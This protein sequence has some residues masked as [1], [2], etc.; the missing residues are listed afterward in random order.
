MAFADYRRDLLAAEFDASRMLDRY[1]HSGQS[2]A[3]FGAPP[4]EEPEFKRDLALRLHEA[5]GFSFI[6]FNWFCAAAHTSA[7]PPYPTSSAGRL[8]PR[9]PI[10]T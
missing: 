8:T 4:K 6:P 9:L 1:F 2:I 3:F 10:L 5:L 7:F